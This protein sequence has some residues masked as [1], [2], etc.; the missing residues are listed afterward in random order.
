MTT[1]RTRAK[2]SARRNDPVDEVRQSAQLNLLIA[3]ARFEDDVNAI[4]QR[5]GLTAPQVRVLFVACFHPDSEAGV[6]MSSIADGIVTRAGDSTRLVD[7]LVRA[8]LVSRAP[9]AS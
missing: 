9:S 1:R 8:G 5:E 3:A 4:C 6:P 7:R 2:S